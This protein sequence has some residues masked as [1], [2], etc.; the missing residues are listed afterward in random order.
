MSIENNTPG[1]SNEESVVKKE[2]ER[3]QSLYGENKRITDGNYD[4]SLAVKCINGTFVGKKSKDVIA[5]KGIPFVGKQPA[6]ELRWKAPVDCVSDDG[7]YE[8]YYFGRIPRQEGSVSQVGSLYPQS[9]ECLFLNI[10][11]SATDQ[12]AKKPVM[13][14]IHGGA[15]A[16]G[17]TVEPREEGTNFVQENPSVIL[18]TLEYRLNVF[19][20][21]HLS[22]LPDGGDYP[23][24]QN[25]GL[26][27][28]VMALKWV[29]ENIAAFGGD[30]D[31]VT[32][33][34]ESAGGASVT[35]LPLI[36]G[37]QK[38]FRRVIAES[39]A[40]VF[41]RSTEESIACTN[42]VMERLGC[43]TVADLQ[44]VDVEKFLHES[45][46]ALNL[47]I[48]AERDGRILPLDPYKAYVDGVAKNVDFL[49]G[50][51]K[52]EM[53]YFV[54]GFGIEAY[55][56]FTNHRKAKKLAQLATDEKA[57]VESYCKD[58]KDVSPEYTCE[59]R[60]FDQLVFIAPLFRVSE[61]QTKAGGRNYTYFFTP[62]SGTPLIRSG[63]AIE[64]SVVFNHPE[65]R[66]VTGRAL[67][68][69]FC[70][71]MRRMWVQFAK[72]GNPS[73]TAD[74]SPDGKAHEWPMYDLKDKYM[75]VF[76]EFN[77]HPEK[78]AER[79][80]LDWDRTYFLTK[81]YCI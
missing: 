63:H 25:L 48:W 65:E 19:G 69:T 41:T 60:L 17:S 20:F 44:K 13:V 11:K 1:I 66:L 18:V 79:K 64:L 32:I 56:A 33:F 54:W 30:P 67:D 29:H 73:L 31:N 9:E 68:E 61:N 38:Y 22:H 51:N 72:T 37:T 14:W 62:E 74:I 24:A 46:I 45:G 76:D 3:I 42:E 6:G 15:F 7:V 77:I 81:Y 47:R 70:K 36:D 16:I 59:S 49:Q 50:C 40:P 4:K 21:F 8:A 34:G 78:E 2:A 35:L 52:D 80:I 10:W 53:G 12:S 57:L 28:Q 58:L 71:T 75:M 27:D 39:G 26:L 55:N 23:D 5:Y 43:K